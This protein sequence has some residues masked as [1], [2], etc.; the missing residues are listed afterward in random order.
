MVRGACVDR[1][2]QLQ[3]GYVVYLDLRRGRP[4]EK[5]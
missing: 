1:P 4:D 3:G 2:E 5:S